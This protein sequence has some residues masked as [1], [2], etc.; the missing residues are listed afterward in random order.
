MR[1]ACESA[2][3]RLSTRRSCASPCGPP[4]SRRSSRLPADLVDGARQGDHDAQAAAL[5]I[6]QRDLAAVIHRD[7]ANRSQAETHAA[8]VT[9]ARSLQSEEWFKHPLPELLRN[10]GTVIVDLEKAVIFIGAE[11]QARPLA[12]LDGVIDQIRHHPAQRE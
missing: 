10:P 1:R 6:A 4:R 9:V 5:A 11:L 12:V 3:C 8:G 7:G 2:S